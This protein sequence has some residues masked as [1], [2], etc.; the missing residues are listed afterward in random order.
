MSNP[1][2]AAVCTVQLVSRVYT[3]V[4]SSDNLLSIMWTHFNLFQQ[5]DVHEI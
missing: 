5:C 1:T 3:A 4:Q 2:G